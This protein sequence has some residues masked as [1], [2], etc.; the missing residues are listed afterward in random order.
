M[1]TQKHDF[2]QF[3]LEEA[4]ILARDLFGV[5][6]QTRPLPSERDQNFLVEIDTGAA[7]VLKIANAS[8]GRELLEAQNA[9]LEYLL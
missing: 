3:S 7:F 4:A 9:A 8:E 1:T 2:P 6:G 5:R